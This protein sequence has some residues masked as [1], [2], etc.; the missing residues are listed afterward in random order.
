MLTNLYTI[1]ESEISESVIKAVITINPQNQIF[2]GHFPNNPVLPGIVQLQIIKEI[3][4]KNIKTQLILEKATNIK[5][6]SVIVPKAN[7]MLI[8]EIN[9]NNIEN[10]IKIDSV[11]KSD[12][13]IF[14]KFK[15]FYLILE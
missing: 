2:E 8:V 4:E 1:I 3:I 5:Y 10:K 13:T 15:G 7:E 9:Y 14:L 11:I 12:N 6:I